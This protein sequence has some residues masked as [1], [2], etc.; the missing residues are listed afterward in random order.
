M[1]VNFVYEVIETMNQ[2]LFVICHDIYEKWNLI[3]FYLLRIVLVLVVFGIAYAAWVL[4]LIVM[5]P[6]FIKA[7]EQDTRTEEILK[8]RRI[9]E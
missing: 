5:K 8:K 1:K 2:H 3:S 9:K 4:Y 6:S 7:R